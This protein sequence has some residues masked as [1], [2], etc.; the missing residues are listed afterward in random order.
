MWLTLFFGGGI[1]PVLT[2]V[3]INSVPKKLE[4]SGNSITNL[5]S[6]L[7]GYLPAP[8]VYGILNDIIQDKGRISMRFNMWY[9]ILGVIFISLATYY[10]NK[11]ESQKIV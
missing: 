4:A 8:Y 11:K 7:L 6:N 5:L 2:N 3:I 10:Y 1:V 9:S